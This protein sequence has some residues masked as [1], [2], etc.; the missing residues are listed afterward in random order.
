M[1]TKLEIFEIETY[2]LEVQAQIKNFLQYRD[3][4]RMVKRYLAILNSPDYLERLP[5]RRKTQPNR[6]KVLS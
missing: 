1:N 5:N 2:P 4:K 3:G 6:K